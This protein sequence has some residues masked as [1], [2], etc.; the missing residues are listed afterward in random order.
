MEKSRV[1]TYR[2]VQ[3]IEGGVDGEVETAY[4]LNSYKNVY[5]TGSWLWLWIT[6]TLLMIVLFIFLILWATGVFQQFYTVGGTVS[7]LPA[8]KDIVATL[9]ENGI[10]QESLTIIVNGSYNFNH[11]IRSGHTYQV[12]VLSDDDLTAII[13]NSSGTVGNEIVENVN[14]QV[15]DLETLSALRKDQILLEGGRQP[16][17]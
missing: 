17:R 5:M 1:E 14:I 12:N 7:Y 9:F 2:P 6:I 15:V 3:S 8:N 11:K 16:Q 13:S 10:E 4:Q